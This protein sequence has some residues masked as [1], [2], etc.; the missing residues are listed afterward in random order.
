MT[1]HSF[2]TK[3]NR[4]DLT[5]GV[6]DDT[7]VVRDIVRVFDNP[8]ESAFTRMLSLT[9]RH[10]APPRLLVEQLMKDKD[11]DMFSFARCI[12]RILKNYI[13]DGEPAGDKS[14]GTCDA[15]DSLVYQDGCVTC[16]QCG[17]AKCG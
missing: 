9:L 1:K 17:Y 8:N 5:F 11:S 14:C 13:S 2:K 7:T 3:T 15:E 16:S 12:A 4:Y 6:E 10:G